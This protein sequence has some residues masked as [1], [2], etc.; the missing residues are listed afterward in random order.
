MRKLKNLVAYEIGCYI[1]N[2]INLQN[3]N[4]DSVIQPQLKVW[5]DFKKQL[6]HATHIHHMECKTNIQSITSSKI[7]DVNCLHE[8]LCLLTNEHRINIH[9][10]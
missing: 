7:Q 9:F 6:V 5:S 10:W 1:P 4:Q 2:I 8:L 3:K